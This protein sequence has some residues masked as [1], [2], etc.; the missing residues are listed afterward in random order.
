MSN[1]HHDIQFGTFNDRDGNVMTS[2]LPDEARM[3]KDEAEDEID[4]EQQYSIIRRLAVK[5]PNMGLN[6][7]ILM[8]KQ[9]F[10]A[11]CAGTGYI[12]NNPEWPSG[13]GHHIHKCS[14]EGCHSVE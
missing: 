9:M 3:Y 12:I 5:Y 1:H 7:A 8:A 4:R 10:Y 6:D 11:N 14:E 13:N 2:E